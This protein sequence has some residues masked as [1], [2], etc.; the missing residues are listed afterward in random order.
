M[1]FKFYAL[2]FSILSLRA[3]AWAQGEETA[4]P[5][6]QSLWQ[7]FIMIGVALAFFYLILWRPEQKRRK[8]WT[9]NAIP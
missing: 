4:A 1:K 2:F 6:D 5:P 7:T 9:S 8:A 3:S